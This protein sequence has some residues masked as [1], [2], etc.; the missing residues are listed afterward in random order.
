MIKFRKYLVFCFSLMFVPTCQAVKSIETTGTPLDDKITQLIIANH[1][2]KSFKKCEKCSIQYHSEVDTDTNQTLSVLETRF[3][4]PQTIPLILPDGTELFRHKLL[5]AYN[6][7][8]Q[9]K[10]LR[11]DGQRLI[12]DRFTYLR[13]KPLINLLS[14][15]QQLTQNRGRA[16]EM[17][18]ITIM[19]ESE[20]KTM[21]NRWTPQP[22]E[23]PT[24]IYT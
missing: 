1:V 5:R 23:P 8:K 13:L 19:L 16:K 22:A 20:Y 17:V 11:K 6:T 15:E 2:N 9:Q 24:G 7:A 21:R 3:K 18:G 10:K 12:V 14:M 4:V